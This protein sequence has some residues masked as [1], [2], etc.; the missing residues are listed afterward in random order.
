LNIFNFLVLYQL[1][2]LMTSSPDAIEKLN[3]FNMWQS[4]LDNTYITLNGC[5]IKALCIY[6][7]I[8]RG[9]MPRLASQTI[10]LI[11]SGVPAALS[12]SSSQVSGQ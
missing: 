5:K 10:F 8:I 2:V 4:F 3:N 1:A 9:N 6:Q 7:V 12:V 11:S